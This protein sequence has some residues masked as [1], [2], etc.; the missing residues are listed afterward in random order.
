MAQS[1]YIIHNQSVILDRRHLIVVFGLLSI[2]LLITYIDQQSIGVVLPTIGNYLNSS[3]TIIW[4]GTASMIANTA[5]QTL[6]GRVSYILG[7]KVIIITSLCLLGVDDLL[8]GFAKSG[9][10]LCAYRGISCVANG[11]IM[12]L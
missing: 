9:P 4:A 1:N 3:S 10:Q 2:A 11:G 5:F 8:C 6:Y 12:A 7:R